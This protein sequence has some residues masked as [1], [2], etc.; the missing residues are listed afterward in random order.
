V[1]IAD[2]A[3]RSRAGLRALLS[4]VQLNPVRTGEQGANIEACPPVEVVGEAAD[5]QETVHLVEE[6]QPDVVLMDAR[7]PVMDGLEAT[8][9]IKDRWPE[10]K[11]VVLT[12]YCAYRA[13]ALASGADAFL[14]KGCS[15]EELLAAIVRISREE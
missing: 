11:I 14:V 12:M 10:V 3:P 8:R 1:L 15:P 2:D 5:G 9:T 6:R 13:D 7:M 4:T